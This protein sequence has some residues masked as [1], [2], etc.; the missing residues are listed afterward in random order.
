MNS[1]DDITE[2]YGSFSCVTPMRPE[3]E[4]SSPLDDDAPH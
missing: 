2:D 4:E 3:E 1:Q